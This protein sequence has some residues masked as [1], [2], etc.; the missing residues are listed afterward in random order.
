MKRNGLAADDTEFYLGWARLEAKESNADKAQDILEKGIERAGRRDHESP[1][2]LHG[3]IDC[4]VL[5]AELASLRA[6]ER[7]IT[8]STPENVIA[9]H[10]VRAARARPAFGRPMPSVLPK[11]ELTDRTMLSLPKPPPAS[12]VPSSKPELEDTIVMP[13]Q[14]PAVTSMEVRSPL[15]SMRSAERATDAR[16]ATSLK[17]HHG[18]TED[19]ADAQRTPTH[20]AKQDEL[21]DSGDTVVL[22]QRGFG[23]G[24]KGAGDKAKGP[25]K[26]GLARMGVLSGPAR[27]VTQ[28]EDESPSFED[29]MGTELEKEISKTPGLQHL[30]SLP[31]LST[32]PAHADAR[33][34]VLEDTLMRLDMQY[35]SSQLDAIEETGENAS[36]NRTS[37]S[38][39]SSGFSTTSS[40]PSEEAIS[41]EVKGL[42]A[43]SAHLSTGLEQ[44]GLRGASGTPLSCTRQ[45]PS[46][47]M[48][49][50]G[51]QTSQPASELPASSTAVMPSRNQPHM[52]T[53]LPATPRGQ[54]HYTLPPTMTLQPEHHTSAILSSTPVQQTPT[55]RMRDPSEITPAR[56]IGGGT[57]RVTTPGVIR[58]REVVTVNGVAYSKLELLGRGGTSQV[59][60]VLSPDGRILA[61][62]Q[63]RFDSDPTLLQPVINEIELM[64][65]CKER[66][67]TE[68]IIELVDAEVKHDEQLVLMV[69][70]CGEIDL[71]HMLKRQKGSEINENFIC[72]Y[73]Q[74]M[75]QAVHAIHEARVI[76]GDLKPA[77]FLCVRGALKLIDFGIAKESNADTTKIERD[78]QVGTV[79]Y[80]SPEAITDMG[81]AE[82]LLKQGR[83]SD[84][85]SLGCILYQM[86][87]GHTPFSHYR[88]IWQKLQAIPD[89]TKPISF[90]ELRNAHLREVLMRCL[91]RRPSQRMT[92][93]ELL[94]HPLLRPELQPAAA[95]VSMLSAEQLGE[96]IHQVSAALGGN[97]SEL[98]SEHLAREIERQ[99]Q[100]GT[101]QLDI[102][103][104]V[105]AVTG[106]SR[107]QPPALSRAAPPPPPISLALATAQAPQRG[108]S[109]V[110]PAA[111]AAPTGPTGARVGAW[112]GSDFE[113]ARKKLQP[114]AAR[115]ASDS[116]ILSSEKVDAPSGVQSALQQAMASRR[117]AVE[118]DTGEWNQDSMS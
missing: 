82:G 11:M 58:D 60:R 92:I 113:D 61:L 94:E 47:R 99:Q 62:K 41:S 43:K 79:N 114:V 105:N 18:S 104:L 55:V 19:K 91:N 37:Q 34:S 63:V 106:S 30:V 21:G 81:G 64:R 4:A 42:R 117:K 89:V 6:S 72:M 25:R 28:V 59:F 84:V 70:E 77:N 13:L 110:T 74:Q 49:T 107:P 32:R 96:I 80:M 95:P 65:R 26:L 93:P 56:T 33:S 86:V 50:I 29:S 8:S 53:V 115:K 85:W 24:R 69:M 75:L 16:K 38:S 39:V 98:N 73:W 36:R 66:G 103:A 102:A 51:F 71:A 111:R 116:S 118:E 57:R 14:Q 40:T 108:A 1:D 35:S 10:E 27:R 100:I 2:A 31:T 3:R 48:T 67:L 54:D 45:S 22:G 44:Q 101:S 88:T 90:P 83:A 12:S 52:S 112:C 76:H 5:R 17:T 7:T 15:V 20:G 78:S 87:Y 46:H 97:Q 68:V 23:P 109:S 9:H